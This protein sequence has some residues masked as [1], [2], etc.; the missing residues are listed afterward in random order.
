M[1]KKLKETLAE[2]TCSIYFKFDNSF[3]FLTKNI[4]VITFSPMNYQKMHDA[5][6][7]YQLGQ[8]RAFNYQR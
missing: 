7:N 4:G 3:I 1:K 6:I 2:R 5:P 8:N